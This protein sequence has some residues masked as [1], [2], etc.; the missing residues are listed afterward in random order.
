MLGCLLTLGP[1]MEIDGA[2]VGCVAFRADRRQFLQT[3]VATAAAGCGVPSPEETTALGSGDATASGET[4]S[5]ETS[6]DGAGPGGAGSAE[7]SSSGAASGETSSGGAASG[8][9]ISDPDGGA[10][11]EGATG[12]GGTDDNP[13]PQLVSPLGVALL[14]L[15]SYASG[16][17]APALQ[18]TRHCR[19]VGIVTGTPSKAPMWQERYGIADKNVYSY[20]NMAELIDNPDIHVVYIVTPNHVHAQYAIAA[21]R[22]KKHVWCEKPMAMTSEECHSII[23]ACHENGVQLCIGYR[24][25]HEPNTQ[26]VIEYAS[27]NP[28]GAIVEVEARAGFAGYGPGDANIWRLKRQMGGGALYDMGVYCINAA[29]YATGEE[30]TRVSNARQW[31]ERPELFAEV[32][33]WT[34]FDLEFPS[35]IIAHCRTSFGER[36]D[37]LDV[38]C[39]AGSYRLEPMQSYN[40]VSGEASDGTQLN[41]RIENQ[42]AKQMDD[43]ALAIIEQRAVL[44]PGEEGLRDVRIVEAIQRSVS[45]GQPVEL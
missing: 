5:G 4:S 10:G 23:E 29:R 22:A 39:E 8:E 26:T 9:T 44:V 19:L 7:T 15:G 20:E 41:Q 36:L 17:L 14:G 2:K 12:A 42:Q 31:T 13:R 3:V 16:Q 28:F 21:A 38:R 40:G 45:T 1:D 6:S 37:S 11:G 30:P 32:D 25:Q 34:E 24:L 27:S 18:L 43:D 33:E 35:G